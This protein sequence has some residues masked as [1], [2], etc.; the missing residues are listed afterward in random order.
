M[1]LECIV[2]VCTTRELWP[3]SMLQLSSLYTLLYILKGAAS[4]VVF[5]VRYTKTNNC[6]RFF[7][8]IKIRRKI[9]LLTLS[10]VFS[11][12]KG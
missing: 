10:A 6:P 12:F 1:T 3:P 7:A 5:T 2:Q 11:D 4:K 8:N 9:G